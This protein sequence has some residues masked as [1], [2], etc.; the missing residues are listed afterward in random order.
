MTDNQ[1][2]V[3]TLDNLI[4]DVPVSEQL[5]AALDRMS[6]KDHTHDDYATRKEV[7][8]LK[9]KVEELINL[10]GDVPVAEQINNAIELNKN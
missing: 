4:G 1:S 10:V 3:D 6:G 5:G 2:I 7:D 9:K 8:E